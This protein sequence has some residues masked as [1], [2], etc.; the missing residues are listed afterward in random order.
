M[1]GVEVSLS[2]ARLTQKYIQITTAKHHLLH[3]QCVCVVG[4]ENKDICS[5]TL[6][7]AE[8]KKNKKK[9]PA[10]DLKVLSCW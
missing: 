8:L 7:R 2:S 9:N 10:I 5:R 4:K 6:F 1:E 3:P